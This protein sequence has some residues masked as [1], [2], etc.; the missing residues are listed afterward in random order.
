MLK[1]NA[2][3]FKNESSSTSQ[4]QLRD[5][6]TAGEEKRDRNKS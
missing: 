4:K 1:Q 6:L 5:C 3:I 2:T